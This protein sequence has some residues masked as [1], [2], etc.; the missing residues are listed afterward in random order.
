MEPDGQ[1]EAT[2][3]PSAEPAELVTVKVIFD[4]KQEKWSHDFQV[5][6]GSTVIDLKQAMVDPAGPPDDRISF[7]LLSQR[8]RL[9]NLDTLDS[10]ETLEFRFLGPQEG[11]RLFEKDKDVRAREEEAMRRSREEEQRRQEAERQRREDLVRE[12]EEAERRR[13][14]QEAEA[15]D[16]PKAADASAAPVPEQQ[17]AQAPAA[18]APPPQPHAAAKQE[19]GMGWVWT[20]KGIDAVQSVAWQFGS[21]EPNNPFTDE[22]LRVVRGQNP[23]AN[24]DRNSLARDGFISFGKVVVKAPVSQPFP[25]ATPQEQAASTTSCTVTHKDSRE[26][27]S[28]SLPQ[29]QTILDLKK[30]LANQVNRGPSSKLTLTYRTGKL[31]GDSAKLDMLAPEDRESL[32]ASG[33]DLGPPTVIT[34][35]VFHAS[36]TATGTSVVLDV[37]DTST[38]QEVK[39]VLCEKYGAKTTDVRL[40]T[41]KPGATGFVGC[42]DSDRIQ[43]LREVG[44]VGKLMDRLAAGDIQQVVTKPGAVTV[45]VVNMKNGTT[46]QLEVL[47]QV[48]ILQLRQAIMKA[49]GQTKMDEVQ[50]V[51]AEGD[52]LIPEADSGLLNGR[53]EVGML[54]CDLPNP[55]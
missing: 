2:Q 11:K 47:P 7:D 50:I 34:F 39:K 25:E 52:Q 26:S 12:R 30:A 31:L 40:V 23:A 17:A 22:H 46:L 10:N 6:K 18:A 29:G 51:R 9:S 20:K 1:A 15:K 3:A 36:K 13:K 45:E 27:V 54:G 48:T 28:L 35:S 37:V 55:P 16:S 49:I 4:Y 24:L 38:F 41:K 5:A 33:L 32:L 53:T 42:K 21:P 43:G 8:L 44:A 19:P 14:E